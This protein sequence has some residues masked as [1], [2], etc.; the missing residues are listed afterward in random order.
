MIN[1]FESAFGALLNVQE[2]VLGVRKKATLG[3]VEYDAVIGELGFDEALAAGGITE[4]GGFSVQI[5]ASLLP[6]R[7]ADLSEITVEGRAMNV[8]R[9]TNANGIYLI[10]AGDPA[11]EQ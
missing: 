4:N 11:T 1:Q 6:A 9:V 7:P 3:G 10:T 8:L 5:K 2:A